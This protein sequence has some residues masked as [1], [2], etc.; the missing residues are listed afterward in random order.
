VRRRS[1]Y[2]IQGR[3]GLNFNQDTF[4]EIPI[5]VWTYN[6]GP[7]KLMRQV[8]FINGRIDE[9]LTMGYGYNANE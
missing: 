6:F 5:E 2:D 1:G 7:Y 3:R 4:V 8:Q 9:I